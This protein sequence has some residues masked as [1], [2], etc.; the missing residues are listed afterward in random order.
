MFISAVPPEVLPA[1]EPRGLR[2]IL[3]G[4]QDTSIMI[5]ICITMV[6]RC[7]CV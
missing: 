3:P 6:N 2:R 5:I 7:S 4:T 1:P